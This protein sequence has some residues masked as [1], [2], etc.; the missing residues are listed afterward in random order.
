[1]EWPYDDIRLAAI[2]RCDRFRIH[3]PE[4][5]LCERYPSAPWPHLHWQC[6]E[7]VGRSARN[8]ADAD[9]RHWPGQGHWVSTRGEHKGYRSSRAYCDPWNRRLSHS[10]GVWLVRLAWSE[11]FDAGLEHHA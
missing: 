5:G 8:F 10:R 3:L 11:S 4:R 7:A 6:A 9:R 2:H 1:M